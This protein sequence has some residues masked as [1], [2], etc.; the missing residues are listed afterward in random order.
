[1][2][3]MLVLVAYL[4]VYWVELRHTGRLADKEMWRE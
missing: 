2:I 3:P 1:M 4:T